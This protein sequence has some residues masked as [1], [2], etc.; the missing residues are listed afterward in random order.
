VHANIPPDNVKRWL[1]T[2]FSA[3]T[4]FGINPA[5]MLTLRHLPRYLSQW[6]AFRR[7][8]GKIARSHM[9]LSDYSAQ[10]GSGKGHYFHQD[11][12]VA[13]FI[14]Q[15]SPLRHIDIGSRIDGFVAHVAAFRQ[16]EVMDVRDLDDCG[17]PNIRFIRADLMQRDTTKTEVADSIS[18]LHALEHFGLGRYG[19]PLDPDGH[20]K[21]FINIAAMLQS[22]GRL[23]VSF[24]IGRASE[25]HFNAHRVFMPQE[26]LGWA[27][28]CES[29]VFER[30][31]YVDDRGQLHREAAL[32]R[33]DID[34]TFGCGIYSF[35]KI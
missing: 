26:V 2:I 19:D 1:R 3:M 24:P 18:C 25:V 6:R 33:G 4:R 35:A 17:H 27:S 10:A 31:D 5:A 16:I 11:L 20:I 7:L 21:G 34:V 23:Y 12:L 22:G 9:I 28:R 29:L 8:G 30:F 14:H 15:R 32:D 13:S